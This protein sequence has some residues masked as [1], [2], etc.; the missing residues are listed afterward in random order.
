MLL[1][2]LARL[3]RSLSTEVNL[4]PSS[5]STIPASHRETHTSPTSNEPHPPLSADPHRRVDLKDLSHS[6]G[7]LTSP[8]TN[9][10]DDIVSAGSS[11]VPMVSQRTP[12]SQVPPYSRPP[13][14]T[15]QFFTALEK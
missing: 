10:E 3:C 7:A 5:I 13:F 9:D 2:P 4:P 12:S 6:A 8:D 11:S 1:R 15:H 14:H